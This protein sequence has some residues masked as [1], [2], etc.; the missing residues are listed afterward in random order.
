MDITVIQNFC[1]LQRPK[2]NNIDLDP[3][4][5]F[6]ECMNSPQHG[7]TPLVNEIYVSYI[8]IGYMYCTQVNA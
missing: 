7:H 1:M 6:R 3:I 8:I 2:Y 4:D 5:F